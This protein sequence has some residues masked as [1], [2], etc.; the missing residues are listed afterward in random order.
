MTD[1]AAPVYLSPFGTQLIGPHLT[2]V[3]TFIRLHRRVILDAW[4]ARS[5]ELPETAGLAPSILRGCVPDMLDRLADASEQGEGGPA[6]LG[7][8]PERHA[9]LRFQLGYDFRQV[10]SEYRRLREV[11]VGLYADSGALP[12][13][14]VPALKSVAML[15]AGI[16]HA[17]ASAGDQFARECNYERELFIAMLGHDLR[18]PLNGILSNSQ[19]LS[20]RPGRLDETTQKTARRIEASAERMERMIRQ[21][22]DFTRYRLGGALPLSLSSVDARGLVIQ[23]VQETQGSR[24]DRVVHCTAEAAAG[25][26]LVR[27][28]PDLMRQVLGNLVHNALIHGTDPVVAGMKDNGDEILLSISNGGEIPPEMRPRLF[29]AFSADGSERSESGLGL[30]LYIVQRIVRAHGGEVNAESAN[31]RTTMRLRLPRRARSATPSPELN[32]A[33]RSRQR[34]CRS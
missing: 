14:S 20:T 24:A 28:D 21:L 8:L 23:A 6:V 12:P 2:G 7:D 32:L 4:C 9:S 11:I 22:L 31:G 18:T 10:V 5:A 30:G 15:N 17:V 1:R 33:D 13:E 16:D 3:G 25:D 29:G 34:D 19:A 26:F 27:W